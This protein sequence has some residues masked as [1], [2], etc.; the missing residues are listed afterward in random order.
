MAFTKIN[1]TKG[2]RGT[3]LGPVLTFR[4]TGTVALSQDAYAM[5]GQPVAVT[6]AWDEDE[7]Q[8]MLT[9]ST[10]D[11]P[12]AFRV[13]GKA[14]PVIP[15]RDVLRVIGGTGV[16]E[17]QMFP[18]VKRDRVSIVADLADLRVKR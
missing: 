14:G 13:D 4:T 12:D 11:D 17:K 16:T 10:P 1:R 6:V 3:R 2:R 15:A 8:L 7:M 9:V 18:V 5:L